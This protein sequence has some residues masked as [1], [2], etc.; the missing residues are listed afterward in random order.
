[1]RNDTLKFVLYSVDRASHYNSLPM[2]NLTHFFIYL[3]ISY[4]YVHVSSII[5]LIIRRS[6]CIN[7]SSGM[8]SLCMWLLGMPA[9][10][11][12][13]QAVTHGIAKKATDDSITRRV[14]FACWITKVIDSHSGYVVLTAF[15]R[16]NGY[17]NAPQW[18]V[19]MHIACLVRFW[20]SGVADISVQRHDAAV[21]TRRH[22]T[23]K[24]YLNFDSASPTPFACCC[25]WLNCDDWYWVQGIYCCWTVMTG[26]LFRG[27]IVAELWWLALG[28]GDLLLLNCD[29]WYWVPGIYCCWTVM[30]GARFRGFIVAELWWLVVGSGDLLLLNCDDWY[31]VQGICCCWTVMIGTGFRGIIVAECWWL[32]LGSGDSL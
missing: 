20:L 9:R 23:E 29:D 28:S 24:K 21:M 1:M 30:I 18:Y 8:I 16:K 12:A 13:Y 11:P 10:R 32:A 4:L 14:H 19:Y 15:A 7:T 17:S 5:V 2:T 25:T 22:N 27:F 6:N 31:S 26:T 3:F